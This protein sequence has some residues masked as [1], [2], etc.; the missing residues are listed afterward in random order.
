MI[1]VRSKGTANMAKDLRR[2]ASQCPKML[3]QILE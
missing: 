1:L 2:S 3:R